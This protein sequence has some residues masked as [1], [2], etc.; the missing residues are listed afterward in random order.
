MVYNTLCVKVITERGLSARHDEE[1]WY[2]NKR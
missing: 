2:D 1:G